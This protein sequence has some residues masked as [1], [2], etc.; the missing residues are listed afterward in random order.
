MIME[1]ADADRAGVSASADD[2]DDPAAGLRGC[3]S[4]RSTTIRRSADALTSH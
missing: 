4:W 2:D 1:M 3:S